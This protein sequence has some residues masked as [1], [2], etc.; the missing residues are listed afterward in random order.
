MSAPRWP[1]DQLRFCRRVVGSLALA[2][3]FSPRLWALSTNPTEHKVTPVVAGHFVPNKS[4]VLNTAFLAQVQRTGLCAWHLEFCKYRG[5]YRQVGFPFLV[6]SA[7]ALPGWL[8]F[9]LY[10]RRTLGQPLSVRR[11]ILLLTAVVYLLCVATLTLTPNRGSRL[12]ADATRVL[13]LR[14]NPA[15]LTC[16][17]AVVPSASNARAFCVQNAAGNVLLFFP[18]GILLPLIWKGL[19]F[20]RGIQIAIALSISIEVAQYFSNYR[21]ADINDV[22][23][24]GLGAC[25]GL[26]L[27]YLLRMRQSGRATPAQGVIT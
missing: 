14:P 17:S 9:R 8:V 5:L 24:N 18:L 25:L 4:S 1:Y 6:L 27:V 16:S 26:L 11:E 20:R 13:E 3:L 10:R 23:L 19:R 22:I 21:S 2:M 12:R 15:S 7:I